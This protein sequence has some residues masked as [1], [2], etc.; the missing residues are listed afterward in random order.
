MHLS[1]MLN[2]NTKEIVYMYM[3]GKQGAL[4]GLKFFVGLRDARFACQSGHINDNTN[5]FSTVHTQLDF[6]ILF[7][8]ILLVSL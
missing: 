3:C 8:C 1:T 2:E 7:H 4:G 5:G 6:V